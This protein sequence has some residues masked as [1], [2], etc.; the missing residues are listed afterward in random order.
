M[1]SEGYPSQPVLGKSIGGLEEAE[2]ARE[3][4]VFHAGTRHEENNYYTSGGRILGVTAV[5]NSLPEARRIA[6]DA[7]S[8][9]DIPGAHYRKDIG[10]YDSNQ[11]KVAEVRANG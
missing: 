7:A 4:V 8:R 11:A 3:V 2:K 6:Y 5:G 10:L 9:I 1:A